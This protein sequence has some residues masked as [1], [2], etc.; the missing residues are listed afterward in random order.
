MRMAISGIAVVLAATALAAGCGSDKVIAPP[1]TTPV[2]ASI[3]VTPR[4]S[5]LFA[6]A[7][8]N[9]TPLAVTAKDQTGAAMTG[10]TLQFT[11]GSQSVATVNSSGLVTGVSA[12]TAQITTS[13]T[14]AGVTRTAVTPVTV[15]AAP[16]SASV[17]ATGLQFIPGAVDVSA[18]GSVDWTITAIPHTITFD[19][20]GA[21]ANAPS[22]T[23]AVVSRTFPTNGA[24]PYHCE[25]H[26]TMTGV[27]TVH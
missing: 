20:S 15:Q 22:T 1:V 25:I 5:T 19:A 2:L 4:T 12:G 23:D 18:G 24:F 8:G 16:A 3:T 9:T 11:S 17:Q 10:G 14:I 6:V 21:P 13:L 27:V 7:P 26:P